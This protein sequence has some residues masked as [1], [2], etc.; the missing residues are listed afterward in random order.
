ML[1]NKVQQSI[2]LL[3]SLK[4]TELS[5]AFSGGKDSVVIYDLAKKSGIVFKAFY[6]NTTLDPA[7]TI[8]FIR[9]NYKDIEILQP[10]KSFFKLVEQKGLPTRLNRYCCQHLKEFGSIGKNVIEGVRASESQNRKGRDYIQCDTRTWQ[11]GA[12]HIYPIYDWSDAD[13]W[14]YIKEN[15]LPIAPCYSNGFQRLGCVGCP[16]AS[17]NKRIAEFKQEPKKL[18][19]IKKAITKGMKN[20]PQWKITKLTSNNPELAIE[21]WLSGKTMNEFDFSQRLFNEPIEILNYG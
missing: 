13:V 15:K 9:N 8:P 6:C 16:L 4:K 12:K 19:A 11:K 10:Q 3:K 18:I 1:S 17:R 5:L 20:N 7:G 21:W 2:I 14:Q